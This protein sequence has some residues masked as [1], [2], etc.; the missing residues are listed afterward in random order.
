[1]ALIAIL[2][3]AVRPPRDLLHPEMRDVTIRYYRVA[4]ESAEE[5]RRSINASGPRD[6]FGI[7]RAAY[8]A[9]SIRWRLPKDAAGSPRL[10]EPE[11]TT[12]MELT[13]PR[14]EGVSEGMKR[15]WEVYLEA[16][17]AHEDGHIENAR[18]GER[19]IREALNA[20]QRAK[21]LGSERDAVAVAKGVLNELRAFDRQ[22]D[23]RT[24]NG[25]KTGVKL[26]DED[27]VNENSG[28][29]ETP[30]WPEGQ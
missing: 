12:R 20:A 14:W 9:W 17:L 23:R 1:M 11:I 6:Q 16:I 8:L 15:R 25:T 7:P 3:A 27:P 26:V 19:R 5:V 30:P 18:S 29:P 28:S 22:Y 24:A 4:G 21:R 2:A 10:S 13:L